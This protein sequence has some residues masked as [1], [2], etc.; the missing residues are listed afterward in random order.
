MTEGTIAPEQI[1]INGQEYNPEDATRFI[2]LGKKYNEIESKLN[3][4]L[5][6]VYPEYTRTT[7]ELKSIKEQMAERDKTIAELNA[8]KT[9]VEVPEDKQNA[10]K[11]ARELGLADQDYLKE[12]G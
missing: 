9:K 8:N 1:I 2:E 7:Q 4:S 12:Q 6:K 3:T 5:D 11:A 10:L